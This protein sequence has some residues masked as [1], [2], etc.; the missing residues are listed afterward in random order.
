[1]GGAGGTI[2]TGDATSTSF[3][4]NDVNSS[5][6]TVVRD[7]SAADLDETGATSTN[8]NTAGLVNVGV[9]AADSGNNE[10]VGGAGEDGGIGGNGGSAAGQG[11]MSS[12]ASAG[13]TSGAAGDA[14]DGGDGGDAD[15]LATDEVDGTQRAGNDGAGGNG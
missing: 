5:D 3:I 1:A 9:A 13:G 14:G 4:G 10:S 7:G 11:G 2:E 6:T 12:N 15:S 8:L